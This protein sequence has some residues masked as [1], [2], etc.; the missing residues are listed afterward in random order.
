MPEPTCNYAVVTAGSIT[1]HHLW[2]NQLNEDMKVP[3]GT[4]IPFPGVGGGKFGKLLCKDAQDAVSTV[5]ASDVKLYEFA[6]EATC[7]SDTDGSTGTIYE[8]GADKVISGIKKGGDNEAGMCDAVACVDGTDYFAK[9]MAVTEATGRTCD[10]AD[11][12]FDTV[13][14]SDWTYQFTNC[15][16]A[17]GIGT[18]ESCDGTGGFKSSS[19][20]S[21]AA[22]CV[23]APLGTD[24]T[25]KDEC[26]DKTWKL[27]KF[28]TDCVSGSETDGGGD[29]DGGND[30]DGT[31]STPSGASSLKGKIIVGLMAVIVAAAAT[32]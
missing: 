22:G 30:G 5:K 4:C 20:T 1:D 27:E 9:R 19:W 6:D 17:Q 29:G 18:K 13:N 23:G 2:D 10:D 14:N 16:V 24:K 3:V 8:V 31:G 21:G 26:V 28:Q 11:F 12:K 15:A 7:K 32:M 25:K